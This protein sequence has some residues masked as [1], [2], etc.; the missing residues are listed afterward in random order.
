MSTEGKSVATNAL[1]KNLQTTAA[2]VT[3]MVKK[4]GDKKLLEYQPYRGVNLTESG[5]KVAL[6]IIRKHRLWE[7]FLVTTLGFSWDEVHEAAEQLE[8]VDNPRLIEKLDHF[9][10]FPKFDPHGDPIPSDDGQ[11]E[12]RKTYYLH[13]VNE[14][15][16][17]VVA[18]VLNHAPD[19]LQYLEKIKLV[20]GAKIRVNEKL[21]FAH[22]FELNLE[23]KMMVISNE[24]AKSIL[25]I[26]K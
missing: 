22:S 1:A 14:N 2:S 10:G 25:L 9:L 19:F 15:E 11:F 3:D 23:G 16:D 6:R 12:E 24:I 17:F 26:K 8:H 20:I 4:L 5:E 21:P 13:E 7:V 18:G